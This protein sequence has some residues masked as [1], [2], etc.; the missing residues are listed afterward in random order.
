MKKFISIKTKITLSLLF[1]F[2]NLLILGGLGAYYI[3]ILSNETN[4]ILTDNYQSV[5][6]S[7]NMIAI[8]GDTH[9][10]HSPFDFPKAKKSFEHELQLQI[11]NIT[12]PGESKLTH[13]LEE[14]YSNFIKDSTTRNEQALLIHA[15]ALQIMDLNLNAIATKSAKANETASTVWIIISSITTI[16]LLITFSFVINIPSYIARPIKELMMG[17]QE[18]TLKNYDKRVTSTSSDEFGEI[19][20][21]FNQ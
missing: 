2:L 21:A 15:T 4:E 14:Q 6:Y 8:I 16:S 5:Q 18:L 17:I 9:F 11:K 7:R 19:A 13:Q 1:L 10:S 3:R 20:N 12:E